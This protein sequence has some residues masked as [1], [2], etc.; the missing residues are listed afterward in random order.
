M[1]AADKSG[2][3]DRHQDHRDGED[4]REK[5]IEITKVEAIEDAELDKIAKA[6]PEGFTRTPK[7]RPIEKRDADELTTRRHPRRKHTNVLRRYINRIRTLCLLNAL[8]AIVLAVIYT[9]T[10]NESIFCAMAVCN[11]NA[12]LAWFFT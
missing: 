3:M 6:Y 1:P 8:A 10:K 12:M 9:E 5:V 7:Y 11:A 4:R 2:F